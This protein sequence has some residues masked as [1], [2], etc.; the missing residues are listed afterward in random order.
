M[1]HNVSSNATETDNFSHRPSLS[2]VG[3]GP[4]TPIYA[5]GYVKAKFPSLSDEQEFHQNSQQDDKRKSNLPLLTDDVSLIE[6]NQSPDLDS[7]IYPVI[8][9][10]QNIYLSRSLLWTL[11]DDNNTILYSLQPSSIDNL[12][13]LIAALAPAQSTD[14][15]QNQNAFIIVGSQIDP[16]TVLVSN[17]IAAVP[18]LNA[19]TQA[20]SKTNNS[21]LNDL[22]NEILSL[23]QNNGA[24]DADRGLNYAL[25]NNPMIYAKSFDLA[26]TTGNSGP[27][28]NGY[29]L[30]NVNVVVESIGHRTEANIIFD[31]ARVL[32]AKENCGPT[33]CPRAIDVFCPQT[34]HDQVGILFKPS[35]PDFKI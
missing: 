16:E 22:I 33:R 32:K 27:N 8:S 2:E 13:Q 25:Y 35:I 12:K 30:I 9:Q 14:G 28:P 31:W 20:L 11:N 24:S 4:M 7:E 15:N 17:I 6:L 18:Q 3:D 19:Q 1:D 29:Q 23:D 26:Y 34:F 5:V 21:Q 10:Q